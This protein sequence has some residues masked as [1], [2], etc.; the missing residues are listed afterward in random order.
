MRSCTDID[1]DWTDLKFALAVAR[2]GTLAAAARELGVNHTTVAR[3]IEA[4][5]GDLGTA[6]FTRHPRGYT[7][8]DSGAL[9]LERGQPI[10]E[11]LLS[12]EHELAGRDTQ[13]HGRVRITTTDSLAAR[14]LSALRGVRTAHPLLQMEVRASNSRADLGRY[15]ADIAVR[16]TS[17]PP[18][19]LVGRRVAR[20][21]MAAYAHRALVRERGPGA[22]LE[23]FEW[24]V[25]SDARGARRGWEDRIVPDTRRALVLDSAELHLHAVRSGLAAG[26]LACE[27][28]A[29]HP[30]LVALTPAVPEL[31]L[32]LW[33]LVH[34]DQRRVARVRAV[35]QALYRGLTPTAGH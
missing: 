5:E 15:Q 12:I 1:L 18:G 2:T 25:K 8:T 32:E 30:E 16:I 4:L 29:R 23:A 28:A 7:P 31:E 3:R 24:V 14:V 34:P 6:L 21:E 11:A 33:V 27:V 17:Q 19:D 22:A 20:I 26:L 10:D 13:I 9:L 35:L